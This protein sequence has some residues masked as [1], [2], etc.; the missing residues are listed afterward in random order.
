ME[1]KYKGKK[2]TVNDPTIADWSKI[3]ALQ[4]WTNEREFSIKLM[5][6]ITGLTEEEIENADAIEVVKATTELSS[7]LME[8]SNEFKNEIEFNDKKYKFLDLPNLTFGEFI[9]IDTFLTKTPAEKQREMHLLMAMLYREVDEKGNYL[10]YNSNKLQARAEEF[11][12]LPV[13]YLNGAS[14]FFLRLDRIL[15]GGLKG[16]FW[17][18]T[19]MIL[20]MIWLLVK[21]TVLI[22]FG[23]GLARLYLY[24]TT[25]LQ[26]L[27][28]L[29]HIR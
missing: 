9:D 29:L 18:Q 4:E 1:L 27:K 21:F 3:I 5:S 28:R 11:K 26:K 25:T 8:K 19:K 10:P 6:M 2:Y 24:L 14:T 22:S 23:L 13:R 17:Q 16:S 7:F 12:K 15:R 20:K